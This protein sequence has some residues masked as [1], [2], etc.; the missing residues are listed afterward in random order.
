[1]QF[2]GFADNCHGVLYVFRPL[3]HFMMISTYS[4]ITDDVDSFATSR[5]TVIELTV[6][7][8]LVGSIIGSQG[9]NIKQVG[10]TAT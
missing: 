2:L 1:M 4:L 7:H 8:N 3:P 6:P 9:S 5:Q 10:S